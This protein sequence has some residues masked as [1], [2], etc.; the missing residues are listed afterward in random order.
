MWL[1]IVESFGYLYAGM[2]GSSGYQK[3]MMGLKSWSLVLLRCYR[4]LGYN[5]V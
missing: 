1:D 5:F 3:G 4:L 2:L